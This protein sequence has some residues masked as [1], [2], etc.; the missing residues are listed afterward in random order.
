[1]AGNIIGISKHYYIRIYCNF[2]LS[3]DQC[4]KDLTHRPALSLYIILLIYSLYYSLYFAFFC[5][6]HD[7]SCGVQHWLCLTNHFMQGSFNSPESTNHGRVIMYAFSHS[8]VCAQTVQNLQIWWISADQNFIIQYDWL[9][10]QIDV[11]LAHSLTQKVVFFLQSIASLMDPLR[12]RDNI[13]IFTACSSQEPISMS[14]P[15]ASY[16][17][18]SWTGT[19]LSTQTQNL[20][21]GHYCTLDSCTTCSDWSSNSSLGIYSLNETCI[22]GVS[23]LL[24]GLCRIR[25]RCECLSC[26]SLPQH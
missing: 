23:S 15:C 21:S 10:I 14:L 3:G 24:Q 20:Q 6:F 25:V 9:L 8:E 12:P 1:M 13:W 16:L 11:M 22:C 26:G 18:G 17:K 7:K 19:S 5:N 2:F 4:V